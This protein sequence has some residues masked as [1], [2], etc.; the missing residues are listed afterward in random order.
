MASGGPRPGAGRRR[1][2]PALKALA[3]TARSDR[4]SGVAAELPIAPMIVPL[5]LSDLAQLH[6][7]SIAAMLQEQGRSSPHFAEVVALLAQ[8][9]E[10]IQRWQAV[11]ETAGDTYE[12]VTAT[13]GIMIR[14]RPEVKFLSDAM[15]HAQSLAV[16]L[17][18]TPSSA[19][20]LAS[21]SKPEAG[22]FDD[23]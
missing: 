18:L 5:H 14:A 9:L 21:G 8:R 6:F 11:L 23:F 13:G 2:D 16:D 7:G 10:Q 17:M 22:E 15:R 19:L 4:E 3:G 12:G 1:K 20:R